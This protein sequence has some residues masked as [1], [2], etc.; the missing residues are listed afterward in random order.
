MLFYL[1]LSSTKLPCLI[2]SLLLLSP[3][4]IFSDPDQYTDFVNIEIARAY[5]RDN[6]YI[7]SDYSRNKGEISNLFKVEKV[8]MENNHMMISGPVILMWADNS[9]GQRKYMAPDSA[10]VCTDEL[11]GN[12]HLGYYKP[13][14]AAFELR[15]LFEATGNRYHGYDR[16][17]FFPN[18]EVIP[19]VKTNSIAELNK[20]PKVIRDYYLWWNNNASLGPPVL[21]ELIDSVLSAPE[22]GCKTPPKVYI[23]YN[24]CPGE[25]C[26]YGTWNTTEKITVY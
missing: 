19:N 21:S 18:P 7:M 8:Y 22:G 3:F 13:M 14:R 11:T 12:Y 17:S 2:T 26:K 4:T 1:M 5:L 20:L 9:N 6:P 23:D 10:Q 16:F 25:G 24:H 15:T